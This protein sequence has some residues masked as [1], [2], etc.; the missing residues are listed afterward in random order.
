MNLGRQRRTEGVFARLWRYRFHDRWLV[1]GD[2]HTVAR[3]MRRPQD[4]PR[5]WPCFRHVAI[6][7]SGG[8]DGRDCEFEARIK[9]RMPYVLRLAFQIDEVSFPHRYHTEVRGDLEG[10]GSGRL[11]QRGNQVQIDFRLD[12]RI[13]RK[14]L[15]LLYALAHPL[16][17]WQ[18]NGVMQN[19]EAGL[20]RRLAA[21]A[22][23]AA[24]AG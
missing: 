24:G 17:F 14:S 4:I 22:S 12:V 13:I 5:W 1:E 8:E 7:C 6:E 2:V 10:Q 18:H 19:G 15:R 21:G 9:G 3:A 23:I 11:T 20:R 16:G